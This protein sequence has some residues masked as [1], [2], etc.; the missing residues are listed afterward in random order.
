MCPRENARN[1]AVPCSLF[2]EEVGLASFDPH[3]ASKLRAKA[4]EHRRAMGTNGGTF[5]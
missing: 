3:E 2:V 4:E 1:T 5:R